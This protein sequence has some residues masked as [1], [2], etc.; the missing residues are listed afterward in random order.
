MTSSELSS[1][2]IV[3]QA[4]WIGAARIFGH[5]AAVTI[6]AA[7]LMWPALY[8]GYPLLYPDSAL[9]IALSF[10]PQEYVPRGLTYPVLMH[11]LHA[12][13]SLWPVIAAQA[14]MASWVLHETVAA[15][16]ARHRALWLIALGL[17]L[18]ALTGLPWTVDQVMP[19]FGGGLMVLAIALVMLYGGEFGAVRRLLLLGV[20]ALGVALHPSHAPLAIGM[21][22]LAALGR[23]WLGINWRGIGQAAM[24]AAAGIVIAVA[25]QWTI[26]GHPYY[27]QGG[28]QFLFGRLVDDGIVADYL[29]EVCPQPALRLC[30]LKDQMPRSH[31]EYLWSRPEAFKLLGG[32]TPTPELRHIILDSAARM[33]LRHLA[34]IVADTARQLV[35]I[36][37]GESLHR[38]GIEAN[39]IV[40]I[41]FPHE[42]ARFHEARQADGGIDRLSALINPFQRPVQL[43][44][45]AGLVLSAILLARAGR[46]RLAGFGLLVLAAL[47]M[48]A[49]VCGVFSGT[50]E[51]YQSRVAWLAVAA[52]VAMS[53]GARRQ[54][55]SPATAG[56]EAR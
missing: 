29:S 10:A 37:V 56:L 39:R 35:H 33:P 8:N 30:A 21:V 48:N 1:P 32:W 52:V 2:A 16:C 19:D 25:V 49:F 27:S 43:A 20:V 31:N 28:Q 18:A 38:P 50:T 15:F 47:V 22:V 3:R 17:I 14:L 55:R 13:F 51:R 41:A 45:L 46:R 36:D 26:A 54:E 34:A 24:A 7:L 44:A 6:V 5:V 42:A 4:P 11:F 23:G 9:Y 40:E 12:G 53:M